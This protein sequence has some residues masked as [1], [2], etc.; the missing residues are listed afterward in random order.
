MEGEERKMEGIRAR[1]ERELEGRRGSWREDKQVKQTLWGT[2]QTNQD[3]ALT[4]TTGH[5][6]RPRSSTRTCSDG[7]NTYDPFAAEREAQ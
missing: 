5:C 3:G 1:E 6:D 2:R 7:A 4:D